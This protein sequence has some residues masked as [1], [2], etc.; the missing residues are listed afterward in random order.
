MTPDPSQSTGQAQSPSGPAA[1]TSSRWQQLKAD[2]RIQQAASDV[3]AA[4]PAD[5]PFRGLR[6]T[7]GAV[8]AGYN[9]GRDP[10]NADLFTTGQ[11]AA[12]H[13]GPVGDAYT[14]GTIGNG[15]GGS[16]QLATSDGIAGLHSRFDE[17][18]SQVGGMS[19]SGQQGNQNM[20]Q[21]TPSRMPERPPQVSPLAASAAQRDYA[22]AQAAAGQ[23]H[24]QT[25]VDRTMATFAA[26]QSQGG[27]RPTQPTGNG[28]GASTASA[29][30][31]GLLGRQVG[32]GTS[33][34]GQSE[35]TFANTRFGQ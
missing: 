23:Q 16:E 34:N 6:T 9:L 29:S 4:H 7:A 11:S 33:S 25:S 20:Q 18:S 31:N 21:L 19:S 22:N 26:R 30:M 14:H 10:A 27:M 1:A 3:A 2:P 17:L 35:S 13:W 15:D 12:T 24:L 8:R 28:F 5:E 32:G